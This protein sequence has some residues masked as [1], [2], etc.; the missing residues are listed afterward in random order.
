MPCPARAWRVVKWGSPAAAPGP[1]AR[2]PPQAGVC[3]QPHR[4]EHPALALTP[5]HPL[6]KRQLA[7]DEKLLWMID[8]WIMDDK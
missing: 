1:G 7:V 4:R 3:C 6:A 2:A 8:I 5:L